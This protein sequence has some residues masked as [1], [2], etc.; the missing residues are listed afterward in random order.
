[1]MVAPFV[2]IRLQ[3]LDV[4]RRGFGRKLGIKSVGVRHGGRDEWVDM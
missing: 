2:S 4:R 3:T 1:M